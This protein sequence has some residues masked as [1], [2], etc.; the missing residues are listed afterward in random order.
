[1]GCNQ[2][3]HTTW[4]QG[5]NGLGEKVIVKRKLLAVVDEFEIGEWHVANNGV[6]AVFR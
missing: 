5:I 2:C 4:L 1:M 6:N 3:Q